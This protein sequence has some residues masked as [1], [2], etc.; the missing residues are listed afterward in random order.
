MPFVFLKYETQII[1]KCSGERAFSFELTRTL[2][3]PH[4]MAAAGF[5][6]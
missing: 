1:L 4:L 3:L 6:V 2:A 5:A